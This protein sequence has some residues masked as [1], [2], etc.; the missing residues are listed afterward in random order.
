MTVAIPYSWLKQISPE[1][2]EQEQISPFGFPPPFPW[3]EFAS[4]VAETLQEHNLT[5]VPQAF[6]QW[7][8]DKILQ[9][10]GR[11]PMIFTL[12][13]APLPGNAWMVMAGTEL[14][15]FISLLLTQEEN[16]SS[17]LNPEYRQG[18]CDFMALEIF[19]A[20][21][22]LSFASGLTP[23]LLATT[24]I[25]S[26]PLWAQDVQ[27]S[28]HN[29]PAIATRIVF[30]EEL[31][32]AWKEKYAERTVSGEIS[33]PLAE[34]LSLTLHLEAGST[35][36]TESEWNHINVGDFL[37][38]DHCSIDPS[39]DKG[40]VMLTLDRRPLYRARI[41]EGKLKILEFPLY[42]EVEPSM[43]MQHDADEDF[44]SPLQ[45][46]TNHETS[47]DESSH[48]GSQDESFQEDLSQSE[49]DSEAQV[50]DDSSATEAEQPSEKV[51]VGNLPLTLV[52]ELGRL[53]ISVRKLLEL[54]PGDV[55]DLDLDAHD[56]IDLVVNGAVIGKGELLKIG[57]ALGV[58]IL[59]KV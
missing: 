22:K 6:G 24:P 19:R 56:A 10:F 34:K 23:H 54:Q 12:D 27:F 38:L 21:R 17:L 50:S 47:E 31:R 18:F 39:Q 3:A 26:E 58:R 7:E 8:A 11:N 20:F 25:P 52:I 48:E 59:D 2:L 42:H 49:V 46:E 30:S 43:P 14:D 37:L 36:I 16:L 4:L 29:S 28:I 13:V 53:Q 15:R 44:E 9:G 51:N 55:L 40:R 32:L 41:K 35:S 33:I 57:E 45:E 5:V 1:L